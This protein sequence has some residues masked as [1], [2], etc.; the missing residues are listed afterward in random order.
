MGEELAGYEAGGEWPVLSSLVAANGP[1]SVDVCVLSLITPNKPS[2]WV[3]NPLRRAVASTGGGPTPRPGYDAGESARQRFERALMY[4]HGLG[5]RADGDIATGRA[6]HAVR[7]EVSDGA[8]W[9][10]RRVG[11]VGA[12]GR[13][14][15]RSFG[16]HAA[17][18]HSSAW[19]AR[20]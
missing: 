10:R 3:G 9:G 2:F 13:S 8:C 14:V 17:V 12:G 18:D 16:G 19:G 20:V 7:R 4:L 5:L 11:R 6:F 1:A 15:Q